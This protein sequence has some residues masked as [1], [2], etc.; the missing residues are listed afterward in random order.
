MRKKRSSRHFRIS[1]G[2][3][4]CSRLAAGERDAESA[5]V[6]QFFETFFEHLDWHR[7]ARLIE[8][9]A[10]AAGKIAAADNDHLRQKRAVAE[11]GKNV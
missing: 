1:R 2:R 10:I 6:F 9:G 5:E 7:F 4:G 11:T 8:L 3:S